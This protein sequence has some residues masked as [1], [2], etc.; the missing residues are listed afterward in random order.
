MPRFLLLTLFF[1]TGFAIVPAADAATF[2][3]TTSGVTFVPDSVTVSVGDT[4]QWVWGGAPNHTVTSGTGSAD[5]DAG[6]LY[7]APLNSLNPTFSYVFSGAGGIYPYFCRLHELLNMDGVVIV[8]EQ[9]GVPAPSGL[10]SWSRIKE[11]FR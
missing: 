4:V 10:V 6:A 2:V 3:V 5:P 7:D 8:E 11:V 9:V 1:A